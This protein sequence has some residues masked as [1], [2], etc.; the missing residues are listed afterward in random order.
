YV[1]GAAQGTH[2]CTAIGTETATISPALTDG[3]YAI[4]YTET[5][6]AG[7]ESGQSPSL[8]VTIDAT[9]SPATSINT[10]TNGSP[11]TGIAEPGATVELTT[12]SGATCT[13][14][15]DPTTGIYS[16]TLAPTPVNGESVTAITTDPAG[17]TDDPGIT[18]AS[19]IDTSAPT[20][21]T[22]DTVASGST[23]I[24]GTGENGTTITLS[25]ITCT[26]A[27]IIVVGGIWT[28]NVTPG[29]EPTQGDTITATSIDGA[30]N[31]STG[32]Y[33]IP[34]LSSGGSGGSE[35]SGGVQIGT[36]SLTRNSCDT[37]YPYRDG[38]SDTVYAEYKACIVGQ[39][40]VGRRTCAQSW[41]I[42]KG[43]TLCSSNSQCGDIS[44]ITP[45]VTSEVIN[46]TPVVALDS[47]LN[48]E[49]ELEELEIIDNLER[50]ELSPEVVEFEIPRKIEPELK[51]CKPYLTN[52]LRI[53]KNNNVSE[54]R[55]LQ[56][57]LNKNEGYSNLRNTG[58]FG[59]ETHRSVIEFQ[60]KY[61]SEVLTPW[62]ITKGTGWV[63]KTTIKKINELYCE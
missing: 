25:P 32:T 30:G 17:N 8:S 44:P 2:T 36:C 57:F 28:C 50:E 3:S 37:R 12:P 48:E 31:T 45:D 19:G 38:S 4:T 47:E 16:C 1:D 56:A 23:T 55:K 39:S 27:P 13:T 51:I 63:Y 58:I 20:S 35:A 62:N 14:T 43:Y 29:E 9:L 26:N 7:N 18:Q 46:Y 22:I 60:E 21:P 54:V 10:P 33:S 15:A 41:A 49:L 59:P 6:V 40:S 52:Y 34:N 61:A 42:A 53:D 5:D 11:V 24:T